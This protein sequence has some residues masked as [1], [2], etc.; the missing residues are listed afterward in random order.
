[1]L[2][3]PHRN[4]GLDPVDEHLPRTKG[5]SPMCGRRGADD[6]RVTD[7]ETSD[8]MNGGKANSFDLLLDAVH[9][10]GHLLFGHR[11]VRLVFEQGDLAPVI[12]V[13]HEAEKE[14]DGAGARM[15]YGVDRLIDAQRHVAYCTQSHRR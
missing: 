4:V 11:S 15:L 6:S 9:D 14:G 7:F 10:L 1:M 13:A 8:P 5:L 2:A 3:F 12:M